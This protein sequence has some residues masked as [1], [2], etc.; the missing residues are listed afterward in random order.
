MTF[1]DFDFSDIEAGL[2]GYPDEV[3]EAVQAVLQLI[4]PELVSEAQRTHAWVNRSGDAELKLNADAEAVVNDVVT[5]Y[6]A[7]GEEVFYGWYLETQ[8]GTRDSAEPLPWK[9]AVIMPVLERNHERI[10]QALREI[11]T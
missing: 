1:F 2:H 8:P 9:Y 4:A 6:L 5:L 3:A 10:M 11:F 7:H